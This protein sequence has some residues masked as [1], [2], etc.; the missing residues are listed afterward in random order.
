[1]LVGL[2]LFKPSLKVLSRSY[3][4]TNSFYRWGNWSSPINLVTNFLSTSLA[5]NPKGLVFLLQGQISVWS[6]LKSTSL[7]NLDFK[8]LLC[9]SKRQAFPFK[10]IDFP[11]KRFFYGAISCKKNLM[12]VGV[13][14]PGW[15]SCLACEH[16]WFWASLFFSMSVSVFFPTN[17]AKDLQIQGWLWHGR[18]SLCLRNLKS[19]KV[20]Q[21]VGAGHKR[22]F[23][24]W[25][26]V[27][28]HIWHFANDCWLLSSPY[29]VLNTVLVTVCE[30]SLILIWLYNVDAVIFSSTDGKLRHR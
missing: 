14:K 13:R 4:L 23:R 6:N 9:I 28:L 25:H 24:W 3:C 29:Y 21:L 17:W 26:R 15:N 7:S 2:A 19:K 16:V 22:E 18:G 12:Y 11:L 1:M 10:D 5:P 20:A 30:L 8:C 27:R